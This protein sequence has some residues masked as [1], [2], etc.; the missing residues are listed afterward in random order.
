MKECKIL[1]INDGT[2]TE[3]VNGNCHYVEELPW[4]AA[5]LN[6][7][8]SEGYT[9]AHIVPMFNPAIQKPGVYSFYRGGYTFFLERECGEPV[10]MIDLNDLEEAVHPG[11]EGEDENESDIDCFDQEDVDFLLDDDNFEDDD[12]TY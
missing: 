10:E 12:D 3:L 6:K 7:Y 2:G 9:V 1:T 11:Y 8:V 4:T 5:V